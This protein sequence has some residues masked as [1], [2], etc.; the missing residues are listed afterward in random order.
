MKRLKNYQIDKV[1]WDQLIAGSD[2]PF[3][4]HLS[5]YLDIVTPGWE[6]YVY[7]NY[8]Y[9]LPLPVKHKWRIPYLVQPLFCQ[10]L[11]ITGSGV[12]DVIAGVF[13]KKLFLQ[14]PYL[15]ILVN[16]LFGLRNKKYLKSRMNY[17]LN[18][19]E[20]FPVLENNF[21]ENTRRNIKKAKTAN[22]KLQNCSP[23]DF[24]NFSQN[25]M[26]GVNA[27][28]LNLLHELTEAAFRREIAQIVKVTD[29]TGEILCA[30]CFLVWN[31]QVLY[32]AGASSPVGKQNSA[33]FLV[34]EHIIR[35]YAATDFVL[36][37]EG[38]NLPGV[39][40]F[41]RGFGAKSS[42]YYHLKIFWPG[43]SLLDRA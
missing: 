8:K 29:G 30:A 34:M 43:L 6:A 21:T 24:Y 18:L 36:D 14:F 32:L 1:L 19:S 20:D 3:V 10:K 42:N 16:N 2:A 13:Y 33:M 7:D 39:A 22:L 25:W 11:G 23:G 17:T 4:Y 35:Q 31:N 5:W 9:L 12:N 26:Q 27:K 28:Q 40:Q 41:F 15:N 37:F 38:S